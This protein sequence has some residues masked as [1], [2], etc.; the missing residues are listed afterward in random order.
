MFFIFVTLLLHVI[1]SLF[2]LSLS[3]DYQV[4]KYCIYWAFRTFLFNFQLNL[5]LNSFPDCLKWN[6][7]QIWFTII[8]IIFEPCMHTE[9]LAT[10]PRNS[11]I[12]TIALIWTT[13]CSVSYLEL[14]ENTTLHAC[15]FIPCNTTLK[16]GPIDPFFVASG[17]LAILTIFE[18]LHCFCSILP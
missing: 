7:L 16:A 15:P 12:I 4:F 18:S 3:P 1:A 10:Y 13:H 11:Y 17:K 8:Y 2:Y 6:H 5:Q 14:C 9:D